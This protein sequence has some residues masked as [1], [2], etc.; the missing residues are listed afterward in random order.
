MNDIL[1][2]GARGAVELRFDEYRAY[3]GWDAPLRES[4][5]D[6]PARIVHQQAEEDNEKD[7]DGVDTADLSRLERILAMGINAAGDNRM[8]FGMKEMD[9]DPQNEMNT[10]LGFRFVELELDCVDPD[11]G[12]KDCLVIV[13]VK[14]DDAV[15]DV[16]S[17]FILAQRV[18]FPD[19]SLY[20]M[21]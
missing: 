20:D 8:Y 13:A 6:A 17:P 15:R 21:L 11:Y 9:R 7:E 18:H 12:T 5:F 3:L 14:L 4:D 1:K 16:G 2:Q 19:P 10:C